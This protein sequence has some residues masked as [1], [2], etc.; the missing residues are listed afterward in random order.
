MRGILL[1]ILFFSTHHME[2]NRQK[3]GP[4]NE[5]AVVPFLFPHQT[6]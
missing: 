2:N 1:S 3:I 4:V 6:L 5:K